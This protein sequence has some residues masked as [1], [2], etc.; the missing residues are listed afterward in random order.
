MPR[1]V[2]ISRRAALRGR[3]AT[4]A[5]A[6]RASGVRR[7]DA[8]GEERVLAGATAFE[9]LATGVGDVHADDPSVL[10]VDLAHREPGLLEVGDD[11][12]HARGL[13]LLHRRELT[14][15]DRPEAFDGGERGEAGG[16]EV[17]A[18][19][20][21]LLAHAA[22][23][24]GVGQPQARRQHFGGRSVSPGSVERSAG[25]VTPDSLPN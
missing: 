23:E 24:P 11:A 6:A 17:V 4:S 21:G 5:S 10:R 22:G 18:R 1:A 25:V 2:A 14:E 20:Q 13:H 7:A 3:A 9:R 15:G 16:G 19:A 12:G 8:L